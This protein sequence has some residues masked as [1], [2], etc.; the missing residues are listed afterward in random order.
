[1]AAQERGPGGPCVPVRGDAYIH[2][3]LPDGRGGN[4]D[5]QGGQLAVHSVI[6]QL[7]FSRT[8]RSTSRRIEATA[9]GRPAR[10]G[11]QVFVWRWGIRSRCHRRTVSGL[12]IRC[13]AAGPSGVPALAGIPAWL[14]GCVLDTA[15]WGDHVGFPLGV[16]RYQGPGRAAVP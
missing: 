2:E 1:L 10:L 11:R 14:A 3:D 16:V 4:L 5:A 12:T 7:G 9:R 6:P 15:A 8:R 13:R